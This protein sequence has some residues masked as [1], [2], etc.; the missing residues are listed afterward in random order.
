VLGR[1]LDQHD[2]GAVRIRDPHFVQ[3]PGLAAGFP[4][5]VRGQ[6]PVRRGEVAHLQPERH[7]VAR[8]PAGRTGQLQ[9]AATQ[10]EHRAAG[11]L[12]GD[13]QPQ[14]VPVEGDAA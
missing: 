7:L 5:D 2:P 11:E 9:E 8:R 12:A 1:H 3:P 6:L 10:E 13:R 14:H 4:D